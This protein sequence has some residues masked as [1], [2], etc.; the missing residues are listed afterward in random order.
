MSTNAIRSAIAVLA[1]SL[2]GLAC[3]G[4]PDASQTRQ[5]TEVGAL[6]VAANQDQAFLDDD[7]EA[8]FSYYEPSCRNRVDFDLFASTTR[9][10]DEAARDFLGLDEDTKFEAR[11]ATATLDGNE[12]WVVA[13]VYIGDEPIYAESPEEADR[14]VFD[15]KKWWATC[16]LLEPIAE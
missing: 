10:G 4:E 3:S 15:G 11:N 5:P 2:I 14:Y 16:D 13:D 7:L 12:A 8:A 6:E 9:L 1:M